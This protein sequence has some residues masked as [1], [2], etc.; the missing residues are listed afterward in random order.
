MNTLFVTEHFQ[1]NSNTHSINNFYSDFSKYKIIMKRPE[2]KEKITEYN[3]KY[4]ERKKGG[5][6]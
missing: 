5:K 2:V 3:K 1:Q 4:R 6:N